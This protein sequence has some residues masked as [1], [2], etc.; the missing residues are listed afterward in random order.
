MFERHW[1]GARAADVSGRG[2]GLAVVDEL[3]RAHGGTVTASSEPGRGSRFTVR[4]SPP[5]G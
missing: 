3:V 5:P 1:R 2:I 4:A